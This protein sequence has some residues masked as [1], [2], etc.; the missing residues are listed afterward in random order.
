MNTVCWAVIV[1]TSNSAI[2]ELQ[3][4]RIGSRT[5]GVIGD[6]DFTFP[7]F[8]VVNALFYPHLILP[9]KTAQKVRA[10]QANDPA[11][12]AALLD[13]LECFWLPLNMGGTG[14]GNIPLQ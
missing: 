11:I 10:L 7:G 6:F 1:K 4:F 12:I 3:Q 5:I 9:L 2:Q 13:K 14:V 8:S